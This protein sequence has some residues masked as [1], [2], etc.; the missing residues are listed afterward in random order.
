MIFVTYNIIEFI[1]YETALSTAVLKG[2]VDIIKL[3]LSCDNLDVN[4]I[5][6]LKYNLIQF[7]LILF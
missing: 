6:I 4:M 2:N 3:L 5:I 7:E 1:F